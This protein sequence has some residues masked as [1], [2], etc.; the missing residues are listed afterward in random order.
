MDV[1]CSSETS[2]DFQ[3]TI[4]RYTRK[5]E[6]FITI[7]VR[8]SNPIREELFAIFSENLSARLVPYHNS[9]ITFALQVTLKKIRKGREI[10]SD[11]NMIVT[12]LPFCNFVLIAR[13]V[14]SVLPSYSLLN[15]ATQVTFSGPISNDYRCSKISPSFSDR[16]KYKRGWPARHTRGGEGWEDRQAVAH[17]TETAHAFLAF[18]PSSVP[19]FLWRNSGSEIRCVECTTTLRLSVSCQCVAHT[20]RTV[21]ICCLSIAA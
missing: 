8:T 14:P 19:L 1:I 13:F 20:L 10:T 2:V 18:S 3:R 15:F 12:R 16:Y 7:A 5:I 4:W 17:S 21:Q 6:I 9:Q 11:E